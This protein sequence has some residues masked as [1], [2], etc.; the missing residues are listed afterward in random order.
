MLADDRSIRD[1]LV[2][3]LVFIVVLF[4]YENFRA[5]FARKPNVVFVAL[6]HVLV[7]LKVGVEYCTTDLARDALRVMVRLLDVSIE[8]RAGG[9]HQVACFTYQSQQFFTRWFLALL[10]DKMILNV[11]LKLLRVDKV[12][13]VAVFAGEIGFWKRETPRTTRH[14][15]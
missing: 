4:Q 15:I 5:L 8:L 11:H 14:H 10:H 13:F 12:R 9:E 6:Q 7:D 1:C 3:Q 2:H